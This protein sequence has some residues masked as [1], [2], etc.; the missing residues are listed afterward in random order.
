MLVKHLLLPLGFA[1]I[2][3]LAFTYRFR[4]GTP[5]PGAD[6]KPYLL[7]IWHQNLFGGI[8]A[9]TGRRHTVIVSR[10]RDGDPVAYLCSRLGHAVVR[11]SSRKRGIDK[12]G[13]EAKDEMIDFLKAGLPGAVTVDGP[14]GP[15]HVVKPGIIEMARQSGAPI[16]PYFPMPA[17]YWRFKSWDAFRLPKPFSRIDIHYGAPVHVPADTRF[18]DFALHQA[19]IADSLQQMELLVCGPAV[20]TKPRPAL[21][22]G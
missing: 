2:R 3:L 18:E 4:D 15:A 22:A 10:S 11:G 6:G 9:Q 1:L 16:V 17:R 12:G 8:L 19:A 13:K 5:R 7:A 21:G 14:S 20:A